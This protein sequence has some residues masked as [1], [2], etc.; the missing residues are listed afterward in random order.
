MIINYD[1]NDLEAF[2]A[3]KK[4]GSFQRAADQLNL[5][6]SAVTRRIQKLETALDT[7]LFERSTRSVRPTLAAKRLQAR[8]EAL[9]EAAQ[10]TTSALRDETAAFAFQKT[11]IVTLAI[12]PSVAAMILPT[13]LQ[14]FRKTAPNARLRVIDRPAN[15]VAEAVAQGDADFGVGSIPMLEPATTFEPLFEDHIALALPH[16]HPLT[17]K[18]HLA[19]DDLVGEPVIVPSQGT[20]NRLL[21]DEAL[22][23]LHTPVLWTYEVGRSTT[24]LDLVADG[25]G[26]ALVPRS[27][28]R[29]ILD[30]ALALR[31]I[32]APKISRPIGLIS[33]LGQVDHPAVAALK[34][35]LA[36]AVSAATSGVS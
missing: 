15:D 11:A 6:Q 30:S 21:I 19:W 18:D 2:L 9:L 25:V 31:A 35:A 34:T 36:Q 12:L 4:T 8:A 14:L 5:S 13:A 1:F 23:R 32:G 22:A 20:G 7:M 24:A 28:V 10:E 16:D 33:G 29:P 26:V 17:H 27:S 3:V